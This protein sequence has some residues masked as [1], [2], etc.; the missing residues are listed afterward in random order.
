LGFVVKP[1]LQELRRSSTSRYVTD[2]VFFQGHGALVT[3]LLTRAIVD[4]ACDPAD[5]KHFYGFVAYEP[6][7]A[8]H[9]EPIVHW[10]YVKMAF[11]RLGLGRELL[12]RVLQGGRAIASHTTDMVM[13][14]MRPT[15]EK[16]GFTYDPYV[17][18]GTNA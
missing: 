14:P 13:G 10:L 2:R 12:G 6:G 15:F 7:V 18:R 17:L 9:A 8:D 1:W 11:R 5:D 16:Y 3:Q 4:L